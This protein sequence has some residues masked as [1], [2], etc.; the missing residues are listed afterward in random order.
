MSTNE[1]A[2]DVER[3]SSER[4]S[5]QKGS[6]SASVGSRAVQVM[7]EGIA[8]PDIGTGI[9]TGA[10][11]IK[12]QET[13]SAG[14][15]GPGQRRRYRVQPRDELGQDKKRRP[16]P[17]KNL[18]RSTIVGVR[19]SRKSVNEV[20]DPITPPPTRLIPDRVSQNTGYDAETNRGEETQLLGGCERAGCEQK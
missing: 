9:E 7:A 4:Q 6:R 20:Q 11:C 14:P 12:G 19:I 3:K 15:G 17:G 2:G 5:C 13:E 16:I 10:N 8:E 1:F 18:F